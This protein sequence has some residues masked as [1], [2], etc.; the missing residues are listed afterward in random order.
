MKSEWKIKN[1]RGVFM[2][3]EL[4]P[5]PRQ[6]EC[7]VINLENSNER[8]SHW[9]CYFKKGDSAVYFD[10]YSDAKPPIELVR[11]LGKTKIQ[12]N[13]NI[14]PS[15]NFTDPAICGHLSLYV[16]KRLSEG[17][18]FGDIT[19]FDIFNYKKKLS[20]NINE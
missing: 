10:S 4:P 3:D 2:K 18:Q 20:V 12:Y 9:V 6:N 8:G 19:N 15:Q 13:K 16:L 14:E 11:Y 1:F 7:G 17:H 5:K